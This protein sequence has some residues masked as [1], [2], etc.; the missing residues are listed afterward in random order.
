[1]FLSLSR[2]I[3]ALNERVG[4][5]VMWCVLIAVLI[6]SGNAMVRYIFSTSSNAWLEAQWYLFAAVFLLCS[7][8]TL[9]KN[10][11]I[12]I[13][14]V[15]GR[16]SRRTQVMI[17]IFGDIVFLFPMAAII[18]YLSVPMVAES[19]FRNEMS[20]DAGG[21]IRW[22]VKLLIPIGF[23]LLILQGLSEFIKRVACLMGKHPDIW[24]KGGHHA[25]PNT[26]ADGEMP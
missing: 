15:A 9:Q 1:M 8:Y 21:L 11:H 20:T 5:I 13:D 12:R 16:F 3:D 6:S 25:A 14:V 18:L 4:K 19:I 2:F 26:L 24:D 10:E 17:D 22:P 23:S 7:G